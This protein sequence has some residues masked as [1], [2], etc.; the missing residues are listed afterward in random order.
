MFNLLSNLSINKK[1]MLISG[2]LFAVLIFGFITIFTNIKHQANSLASMQVETTVV[3]EDVVPLIQLVKNIQINIIQVQQ[4]L[5][6]I[7]A[8]RGLDGLNDGYDMAAE[9]AELFQKNTQQALEIAERN[10]LDDIVAALNSSI[11]VFP[12]YYETG[13]KMAKAYVRGG[14]QTGNIMMGEFDGAAESMANE[15]EKLLGYTDEMM[16]KSQSALEFNMADINLQAKTMNDVSVIASLSS[17][18]T[19]IFLIWSS[20]RFIARPIINITSKMKELADGNNAIDVPYASNQDEIGRMALALQVFKEN[21]LETEKLRKEQKAL[22]ARSESEKKQA[23]EEMADQFDSQVGSTIKNLA[24]AAEKL[25]GASNGMEGTATKT[26]EASASV[27]SAA[28]ETSANA[29]TVASATEEMTASAQEISKQVSDVA[30][31]AGQASESANSTSEKVDQLNELANNIGTVVVAIRDIAEQTNLLA[32]NATIEAARAG[33]SGKGFAVVADEVKKLASETAKKTEE[34]ETRI[35]EIQ[36]ATQD[37]VQA[38]QEII[39]NI[40]D[41]DQ[42]SAGTASAVEEQNSVIGEITRNISEVSTAAQQV[43]SVIGD[44]RVAA[45]DTGE[46]AQMLKTSSDDIAGLSDNLAKAVSSFL[47]QV[48]GDKN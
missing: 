7:S 43:A 31:K 30:L 46:S 5:T 15:L 34:I 37:S 4:W 44:V 22:E 16:E 12:V 41:I 48:R 23:M 25:Q 20:N 2:L 1:N 38:M 26:Q 40:S 27:A 13:R 21:S 45:N 29:G 39:R 6:D 3:L 17:I 33:E 14:P 36:D 28:E 35:T 9:Q 42:A 32:L 11:K 10:H 47:A 8:T 18:L 24:V 19:L